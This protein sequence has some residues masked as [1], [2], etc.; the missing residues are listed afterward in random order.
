MQTHHFKRDS[1]GPC[2]SAKRRNRNARSS[3]WVLL[4]YFFES[5]ILSK[6]TELDLLDIY[7]LGSKYKIQL[8]LCGKYWSNCTFD[9]KNAK[10]CK[11]KSTHI[12]RSTQ[13]S[14]TRDFHFHRKF[15]YSSSI[16]L[17]TLRS[18]AL[19]APSQQQKTPFSLSVHFFVIQKCSESK[20][21]KFPGDAKKFL[22]IENKF[23]IIEKCSVRFCSQLLVK[24]FLAHTQSVTLSKV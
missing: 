1:V 5:V 10:K 3:E 15:T 6:Q 11:S 4:G 21:K 18:G 13:I 2:R 19:R 8:L 12:S 16:L 23:P 24:L 17:T 7:L 20:A 22:V 14:R 9:S